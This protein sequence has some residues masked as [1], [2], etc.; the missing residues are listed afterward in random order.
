M[1]ILKLLI[2]LLSPASCYDVSHSKII[3]STLLPIV[4]NL[5]S[6]HVD[7]FQSFNLI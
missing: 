1:N 7:R 2:V 6:P 3:L 4:L 5:F